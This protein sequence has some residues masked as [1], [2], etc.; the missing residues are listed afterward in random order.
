MFLNGV[1]MLD[2][3]INLRTSYYNEDGFEENDGCK[4]FLKYLKGQMLIDLVC[5]IPWQEFSQQ[6]SQTLKVIAILKIAR[7]PRISKVISRLDTKDDMK[8]YLQILVMI[9]Y[10]LIYVHLTTC[11]FFYIAS[12]DKSWVPIKDTP[13]KKTDLWVRD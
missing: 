3:L 4:I 1:Y 5:C 9:S 13:M 2:I 12:L 7:I 10:L 6:H 11:I 8:A